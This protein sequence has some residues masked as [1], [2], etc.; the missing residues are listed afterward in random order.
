MTRGKVAAVAVAVL[1]AIGW[2]LFGTGAEPR[3][4]RTDD[5]EAPRAVNVSTDE[6]RRSTDPAPAPPAV[7]SVSRAALP[8]PPEP[9]DTPAEVVEGVCVLEDGTPLEG[10]RLIVVVSVPSGGDTFWIHSG[11][12]GGF[13]AETPAGA[14][15]IDSLYFSG[16]EIDLVA[17]EGGILIK[18]PDKS[19]ATVVKPGTGPLR[20]VFRD[21]AGVAHIRLVDADSGSPVTQVKGLQVRWLIP[22]GSLSMG[23]PENQAP[24]GWIP[25]PEGRLPEVGRGEQAGITVDISK[26]EVEFA[27]PGFEKGRLALADIRGRM[28]IRVRP[29]PPDA[30]GTVASP[31]ILAMANGVTSVSEMMTTEPVPVTARLR[32]TGPEPAPRTSEVLGLPTVGG[33]FALYDI[34]DGPWEIE[35]SAVLPGNNI[36]RGKK[37]FEMHDSTTDLGTIELR[38]AGKVALRVVD[39]ANEPIPQAWA[40]IVRPEENP[41]QGR[42]LDLNPLGMVSVGDLEPG[43]GH[44]AVVKGLPRDLEQTVVASADAK[45]VEFRWNEKLVACRITLIVDGKGVANPDG[46]A[47]IP[48]VVQESPLPRDRGAWKADGTFEAKLVPGTYRFSALAT[49][50]EGG[51][52]ALFSGEVTVPSGDAFEARLELQ[53]GNR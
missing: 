13:R 19:V 24:G 35:V 9:G 12:D 2:W 37:A 39:S 53:R 21:M 42:R 7:E 15:R 38:P 52:L 5:P 26:V 10:L 36:V 17:V 14:T 49:P 45:P 6:T 22:G 1:A 27:M 47:T 28:E 31:R 18:E 48:A 30:K 43:I 51:D 29:V 16:V 23:I 44:R 20:L 8:T 11:P 3:A 32:W 50:K 40:V 41:D 25:I 4:A 46:R 33:P 34:P